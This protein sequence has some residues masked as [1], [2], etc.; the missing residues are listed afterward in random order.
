MTASLAKL[1]ISLLAV[2]TV[3]VCFIAVQNAWIIRGGITVSRIDA[4]IVVQGYRRTVYPAW[5][6]VP[7]VPIYSDE[8]LHVIIER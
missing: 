8:P 7:P 3:A 4:P 2:I 1:Q 6:K 5:E